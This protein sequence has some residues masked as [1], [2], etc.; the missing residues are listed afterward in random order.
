M[1]DTTPLSVVVSLLGGRTIAQR[2]VSLGS[3]DA[4]AF[5]FAQRL[6]PIDS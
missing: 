3:K 5:C 6:S 1:L 2:I 4:G